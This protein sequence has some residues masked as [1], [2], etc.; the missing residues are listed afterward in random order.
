VRQSTARKGVN[1]RT[2]EAIEVPAKERVRFFPGKE[3]ADAVTK[4]P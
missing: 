3:L 4:K 2:R 1:P